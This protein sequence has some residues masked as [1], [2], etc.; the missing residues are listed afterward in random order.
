MNNQLSS[1]FQRPQHCDY[2]TLWA[3]KR[4]QNCEASSLILHKI[5]LL[6][7]I[8]SAVP[9]HHLRKWHKTNSFLLPLIFR[10][11]TLL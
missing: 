1:T 2:R 9:R 11:L 3:V 8:T 7:G 6:Y 5:H 4:L 10:V